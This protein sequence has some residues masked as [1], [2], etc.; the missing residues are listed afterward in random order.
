[1]ADTERLARQV[2]DLMVTEAIR[3]RR[4]TERADEAMLRSA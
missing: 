1:M 2:E 4:G 3:D